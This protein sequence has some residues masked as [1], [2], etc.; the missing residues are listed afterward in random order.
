MLVA[1]ALAERIAELEPGAM[2]PPE[3]DL[4]VELEVGRGTLREALRLLELQ[5]LVS[6]KA[7]PR[8]GPVVLKPDHRPLAD[9]LSLFLQ[10][11]EAP[12]LELVQARRAIESDLARL[13]AEHAT[14]ADI[15]ALRAS[16]DAMSVRLEDEDFFLAENLRFHRL[17]AKAADNEVLDVFHSCLKSISDGHAVGVVYTERHRA[18]ILAWHT[19]ITDAI[20]AHDPDASYAAMNDHM[21]EYEEYVRRRYP[22]ILKRRVRWMLS[23]S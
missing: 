21:R 8:G 18:A 14:D 17:C 16:I 23:N 7:G 22:T 6:V 20:A 5:G 3:R 15:A 2:L 12:Y 9:A 1:H 4:L 11:A 19:R 13:A 10:S